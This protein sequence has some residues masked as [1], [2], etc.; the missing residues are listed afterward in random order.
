MQP[1]LLFASHTVLA[2]E[3]L[4]SKK[5]GHFGLT[6]SNLMVDQNRCLKVI[7]FGF[8]KIV[9]GL[10]ASPKESTAHCLAPEIMLVNRQAERSSGYGLAADVW[11]FGIN[12]YNFW[13]GKLPFAENEELPFDI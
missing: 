10:L 1:K 7:G 13:V 3:F 6:G 11:S 5:T 8:A 2:M 12:L 4:H 9:E